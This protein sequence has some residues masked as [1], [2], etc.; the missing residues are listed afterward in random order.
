[1]IPQ[2]QKRDRLPRPPFPRFISNWLKLPQKRFYRSVMG[3][4]ALFITLTLQSVPV[5]AQ[6]PQPN[7]FT[8]FTDWCINRETLS[9]ETQHTINVLL[10]VAETADCEQANNTLT[11]LTDLDLPGTEISDLSPLRSL[12]NLTSGAIKSGSRDAENHENR[13]ALN[14]YLLA[15]NA[16]F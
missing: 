1:M 15:F 11:N 16:D 8:S 9:P 2:H 14:T 5:T 10:E 13:I 4:I 3:A 6:Q 12:T 7:S